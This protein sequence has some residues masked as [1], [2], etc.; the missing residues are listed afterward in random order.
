MVSPVN[1]LIGSASSAIAAGNFAGN[2]ATTATGGLGS[3]AGAVGAASSISSAV[4][5]AAAAAP[6]LTGNMATDLTAATGAV[7]G[8]AGKLPGLPALPGLPSLPGLPVIPGVAGLVDS[9]KGVAAS[10]FSA[11]TSSFKALKAGVPQNLTAIATKN[12]AAIAA[13]EAGV[14][15]AA[16]PLTDAQ[17]KWL[18]N[19]DPTDPIILARMRA[20]VPDAGGSIA[21]GSLSSIPVPSLSGIP[22]IAGSLPNL[23]Q[24]G[25]M[26][27]SVPGAVGK[28]TSSVSA[29]VA[30]ASSGVNALPGGL[31]AISS[32]VDNA[33]GAINS[34]PG[35]SA[36]SGA[37]GNATSAVT[38]GP[39]A[40]AGALGSVS[41]ALGSVSGALSKLG[42]PAS[43]SAGLNILKAGVGT[44]SALASTGLSPSAS[45]KM[46]AAIAS[47]SSGGSVPIKLPIV[48]TNTTDRGELSA[49]LSAVFG[50]T[51]I[52][53]PNFGG[54]PATFGTSQS[55]ESIKKYEETKALIATTYDAFLDQR[56]LSWDAQAEYEKAKN[57]LP[58]GD[59][60]IE[61]LKATWIAETTKATDLE[62]KVQTLREQQQR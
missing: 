36:I 6:T 53:A 30:G 37:I 15:P 41:G 32:V 10:A 58:Q 3:I 9:A 55:T 52:A 47:L 8:L 19:A 22:S 5:A 17:K 50:S 29:T 1:S 61:Q 39:A 31:G 45:A 51:K 62:K 16:A 48:A 60:Q 7:T 18:G 25:A 57:E 24:A 33:K 4:G 38:N 54:N 35:T 14:A 21:G 42:A 59:P 2:L 46:N 11:I 23:S 12:A 44:L 13:A 49:G 26:A 43:L 28:I 40:I 20:A 27:T 56:K 34:I